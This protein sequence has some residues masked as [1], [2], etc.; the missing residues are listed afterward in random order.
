MANCICDTTLTGPSHATRCTTTHLYVC[1]YLSMQAGE[2]K[3]AAKHFAVALQ[4]QPSSEAYFNLATLLQGDKLRWIYNPTMGWRSDVELF[5]WY[6]DIAMMAVWSFNVMLHMP[7]TRYMCVNAWY[8][9]IY[10][11]THMTW[12]RYNDSVMFF[13]IGQ[14]LGDPS[15]EQL[16]SMAVSYQL[17]AATNWQ[18]EWIYTQF[19]AWCYLCLVPRAMNYIT[20]CVE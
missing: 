5:Q 16:S 14:Q 13:E 18:A 12:R 15:F 9:Y 2:A 8:I 19:M 7:C 1:L 17:R 3:S 11:Y 10:I 6:N 4:L 20:M